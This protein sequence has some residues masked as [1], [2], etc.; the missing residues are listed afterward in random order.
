MRGLH[1]ASSEITGCGK[2]ALSKLS[3]GK[4]GRLSLVSATPGTVVFSPSP[5]GAASL[6]QTPCHGS[7][8]VK[9]ILAVAFL[10]AFLLSLVAGASRTARAARKPT[11]LPMMDDDTVYEAMRVY[12]L[13]HRLTHE[14]LVVAAVREFLAARA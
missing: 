2:R 11:A 7:F 3:R 5:E 6:L 9:S 1:R 12:A 10:I 14:Q 13:Q 8:M 4:L